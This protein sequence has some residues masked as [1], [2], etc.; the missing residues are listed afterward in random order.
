MA[1]LKRFILLLIIGFSA[2]LQAQELN[3][4]VT[5]NAE[6]TGKTQLSIFKTLQSSIEDYMNK[7]Q[8]TN[9]NLKKD[10]RINCAIFITVKELEADQFRATIQVQSSRP[11]YG[12]TFTTPVL[13]YKDDDFNFQYTE[14]DPLRFEPNNYSGNL[15][16]NL[17]FFAFT[18]IGLDADTFKL[19]AGDEYHQQAKQVVNIAQQ[20][21]TTGWSPG[22]G[23][24]SKYR[25]NDDLLSNAFQ[26]Y[27][28]ALYVYHIEGLDSMYQDAEKGKT[29]VAEAIQLLRQ[30][31]GT[32]PNSA[33]LRMFFDAKADEITSI[34][35]GG[36]SIPMNNLID[37]LKKIAP[38]YNK[39]WAQL[40]L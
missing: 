27:R 35:S 20:G 1:Y 8:F 13:N 34:Y 29:K 10:K 12:S 37:N 16:A 23:A 5:L 4:S 15:T 19:N 30:V 7:T 6:Q 11:V 2:S 40:K 21:R 3:C 24:M 25:L 33:P 36:P 26:D 14:F 38:L 9:L 28:K 32:R 18:I 31:S 39:K 22:D 17:N